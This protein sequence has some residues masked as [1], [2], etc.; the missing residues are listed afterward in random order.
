MEAIN[1]CPHHGFDT[2]LLV[3]YFYDGMSSSM[4][5]LLEMMC[6]RD[7]MK[8][9]GRLAATH[10]KKQPSLL[11]PFQP[12]S[13][14]EE[15]IPTLQYLA[16]QAKSLLPQDSSQ[17]LK[18][19]TFPSSEGGVPSSPLDHR[20]A[21]RRPSTSPSPEPSVHRIPPKRARTSDPGEMSRH[22]QPEPQTPTDSQRPSRH[23]SESHH[24]E[25]YG[26]RAT[27]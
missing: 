24:Q 22:A 12:W 4:K 10:L 17:V 27:H 14:S 9:N 13:A 16:S 7:F 26:H 1:A 6:E 11:A 8:T 3:S 18:P 21:T 19:W 25:A 15:A 23:C 2:W 20:Y 5:Q